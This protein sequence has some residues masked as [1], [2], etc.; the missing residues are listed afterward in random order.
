MSQFYRKVR[1]ASRKRKKKKKERKR[2]K[3]REKKIYVYKSSLGSVYIE[4]EMKK[5]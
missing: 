3:E 4:N 2:K 5:K 1:I